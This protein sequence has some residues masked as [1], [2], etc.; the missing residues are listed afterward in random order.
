MARYY[1]V[2]NVEEDVAVDFL[3]LEK[4]QSPER[5]EMLMEPKGAYKLRRVA[6]EELTEKMHWWYEFYREEA[7]PGEYIG[8][9]GVDSGMLM[10][11]DPCY[12]K[13]ATNEKCEEIYKVTEN[14]FNSGQILNGLGFALQT[15]Y[16]DGIYEV[17]AKRDEEGRIIKVEI[18]L[19]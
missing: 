3:I 8:Q 10:I 19:V 1:E 13:E 15:G 9:V 18:N 6:K 5:L 17:T 7:T 12:V 16:G 4:G 2:I 11:T 14:E